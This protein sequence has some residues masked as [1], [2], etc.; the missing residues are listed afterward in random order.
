MLQIY[1]V[2]HKDTGVG[3]YQTQ[4]EYCQ[5]LAKRTA[6]NHRL[7]APGD[8]GL[9]MAFIPHFY[10]FGCLDLLRLKEWF[11]LGDSTQENDEIVASL[12]QK[13]FRVAEY[14]VEPDSCRVSAT[15][16][17]VAFD[18]DECKSEGLVEHHDLNVL[19]KEGPYMFSLTPIDLR[20]MA[21]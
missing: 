3:P 20:K 5:H 16:I 8:D 15:K 2:E 14:L 11:F 10:V 4:D 12:S 7:R 13:G 21:A 1:R 19:L 17:Q 6:Y 18:A 9:Y